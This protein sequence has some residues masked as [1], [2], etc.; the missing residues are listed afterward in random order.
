MLI[1][2]GES[3]KEIVNKGNKNW[4]SKGTMSDIEKDS[5]WDH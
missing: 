1:K 5:E 2:I 4:K 3:T